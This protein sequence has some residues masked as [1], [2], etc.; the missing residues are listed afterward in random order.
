MGK[1]MLFL[2]VCV[3]ASFGQGY[4]PWG[5]M[6]TVTSGDFDDFNPVLDHGGM[7][8]RGLMFHSEC[9]W[10]IFDRHDTSGSSVVA[11]RFFNARGIWDTTEFVIASSLPPGSFHFPDVATSAD[12]NALAVWQE[13]TDE[14]WNICYSRWNGTAWSQPENLTF[15]SVDNL[16]SRVRIF[17]GLNTPSGPPFVVAWS[18]GNSIQYSIFSRDENTE[19]DTIVSSNFD[20]LE[21]D[22]CQVGGELCVIWTTLESDSLTGLCFTSSNT[23]RSLNFSDPDTLKFSGDVSN[24]H[25]TTDLYLMTCFDSKVNGKWRFFT[26]RRTYYDSTWVGPQEYVYDENAPD[27]R[28]AQGWV[29]PII[30]DSWDEACLRKASDWS[31]PGYFVVENLSSSDTTLL[32]SALYFEDT[33]SSIGYDRS[34]TVGS[35]IANVGKTSFGLAAWESD[36]TGRSH[37]YSRRFYLTISA[38]DEQPDPASR[39]T[40]YQNYPNPFNPSTTI[41]YRL[42]AVS[43]VTI[44]VYDVLGRNIRTL[45]DAR[46]TPGEHSVVFDSRGLASG[47]YFFELSAGGYVTVKKMLLLK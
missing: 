5:K 24:P 39:F 7:Q 19:P 28:N 4:N 46:Q 36:R 10:L 29:W 3:S 9:Q 25:I 1:T 17:E 27:V 23:N 33:L 12:S 45:V 2:L 22:L 15:D 11:K 32:F 40:L 13:K 18:R 41:S 34:P 42:S 6:D 20:S 44:T 35:F 47:V 38:V 26:A 14:H 8:L 31:L 21:F 16:A 37:I 30:W 43:H